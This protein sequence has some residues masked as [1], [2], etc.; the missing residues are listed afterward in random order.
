MDFIELLA[1]AANN[2]APLSLVTRDDPMNRIFVKALEKRLSS[3]ANSRLEWR[4]HL[5]TKGF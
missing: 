2:G 5:H 3:F 4:N 1:C